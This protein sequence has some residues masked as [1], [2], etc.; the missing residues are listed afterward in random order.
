MGP[1]RLWYDTV[2]PGLSETNVEIFNWWLNISSGHY[3]ICMD[4]TIGEQEWQQCVCQGDNFSTGTLTVDGGHIVHVT[5]PGAY[6][7]TTLASDFVILVDSSSAK[8]INLIATP[9]TGQTYRIK[10]NVGSAAAN[11]ITIS[12]NGRNI[13]GAASVSITTNYGSRDL[14]YNGTQWNV[15]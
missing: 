14:V 11:N 13:D 10:D 15:L 9:S 3:F 12:G 7:Y 1:M 5:T 6:P 8:T 4:D 2:D